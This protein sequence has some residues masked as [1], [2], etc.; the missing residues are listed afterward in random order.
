MTVEFKEVVITN[1]HSLNG[2]IL[3]TANFLRETARAEN[4]VFEVYKISSN[5]FTSD[6]KFYL[7]EVKK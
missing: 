2:L 5:L 7:R 1:S 4:R 6:R 3:D